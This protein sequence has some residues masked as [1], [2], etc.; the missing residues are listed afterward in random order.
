MDIGSGPFF[1]QSVG[2]DVPMLRVLQCRHRAHTNKVAAPRR[3]S[4]LSNLEPSVPPAVGIFTVFA[5]ICSTTPNLLDKDDGFFIGMR[6]SD[7]LDRLCE[8]CRSPRDC[9]REYP[10]RHFDGFRCLAKLG[11][12]FGA[13]E[14]HARAA[15]KCN[16]VIRLSSPLL[17]GH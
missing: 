4:A 10:C 14:L 16:A 3:M 12:L 15:L 1:P 13:K 2:S 7:C 9:E 6:M 5:E 17:L 11:T 8:V